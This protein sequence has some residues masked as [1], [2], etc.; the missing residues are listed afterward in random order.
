MSAS[1]SGALAILCRVQTIDQRLVAAPASPSEQGGVCNTHLTAKNGRPKIVEHGIDSWRLVRYLD[2]DCDI[3]RARRLMPEGRFADRLSGHVVGFLPGHRMLWIEGH[4]TVEGLAD[5]AALGDLEA[6]LLERLKL[7]GIPTGRD[8][9]LARVD[10]TVTVKY[11]SARE[12]HAVLAGLAALDLP[13]TKPVVFGKPPQTVW[14]QSRSVKSA[15]VLARVYDKG[16]ESGR[17][18]VG[19]EIR[20][21]DQRRYTKETRRA[22]Q[23]MDPEYIACRFLGRFESMRR[24]AAGVRVASLSVLS[25]ELAERVNNDELTRR[26][27]DRLI[28]YLVMQQAGARSMPARSDRRVRRELRDQGLVLADDFFEPLD[29]DLGETLEAIAEPW[30]RV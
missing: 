24:S 21:E 8:A 10:A 6:G 18:P 3:D 30:E 7:A 27:S 1:L 23:E 28:G 15:R 22:V 9:G 4:P 25:G 12:G 20:F 2:E 17:A 29:L 13:R 11:D 26:Q 19:R 5:P 14:L 16:L